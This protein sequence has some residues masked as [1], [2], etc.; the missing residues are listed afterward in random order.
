M[1]V[2]YPIYYKQFKCIADKCKHSC[3]VGWEI[4]L[5]QGTAS[6]YSALDNDF[7]KEIRSHVSSEGSVIR[8]CDDGRCPFLDNS[9]L[10][11]II[12]SL[13]EGYISEICREQI[14]RAHV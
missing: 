12:S 9:G 5:D 6:K 1:I 10:C 8:L 7:G 13:G 11:R 3:C 4:G 2:Y 14:E